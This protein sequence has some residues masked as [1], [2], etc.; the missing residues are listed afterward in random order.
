MDES[1]N[2]CAGMAADEI[3]F[4]REEKFKSLADAIA[5]GK[6]LAGD[7][8][9]GESGDSCDKCHKGGR[10]FKKSFLLSYPHYVKMPLDVV[11]LDQMINFCM[12][13][14]MATKAL[15]YGSLE[16]TG[17]AAYTQAVYAKEY[18]KKIANN[19]CAAK[20]PCMA[21]PCNP[22]A[23]NPCGGK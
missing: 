19:P 21:N 10:S 12:L 7:P 8:K 14:P 20:N 16:M 13:N 11:S 1:A 17:L 15:P 4:F 6:K 5:Y 18:A 22:C 2:P 9:L 3:N 23:G